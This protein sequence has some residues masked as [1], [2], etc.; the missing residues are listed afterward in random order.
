MKSFVN[1]FD[2]KPSDGQKCLVVIWGDVYSAEYITTKV[3]PNGWFFP[4]YDALSCQ[5]IDGYG[6]MSVSNAEFVEQP[7]LWMDIPEVDE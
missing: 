2:K 7:T 1:I 5:R 4:I 3:N 6:Y